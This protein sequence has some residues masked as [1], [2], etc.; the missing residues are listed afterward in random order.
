[1]SSRGSADTF[2]AERR[3]PSRRGPAATRLAFALLAPSLLGLAAFVYW[4]VLLALGQSLA[5]TRLG[6]SGGFGFG[7]YARL[8][9][10]PHFAR[11]SLNNLIYAAGTIAPAIALALAFALALAESSRITAALRALI[12]APLLIPLVAAASLAAFIY[13][14]GGGLIDFYLGRLGVKQAHN[15][16][17]DPATALSAMIAVTVW[18]NTGYYMLFFLA[19][20][21][22]I[23]DELME[24]ARL[25]GA[26]AVARLRHVT[27]PLLGPTFGF[28]APIALINALTQIDHVVTLTQGGPDDATNL[29]LYYI[30]QQA[31][32]NSDSGLGA[33][34]TIVSVAGLM[35]ATLL[36]RA[37]LERNIHYAS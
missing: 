21:A 12:A 28:I 16:L 4:P 22:T 7:N 14:P 15:W 17:G 26:G 6:E 2:A 19:G 5:E 8:I 9:A 29:L 37:A 30:Y 3:D 27:L 32:Q 20:L 10:D 24:A 36:A 35:A 1:M 31:V 18:K 13:L 11:A 23:P 25:D 34:A 33:A